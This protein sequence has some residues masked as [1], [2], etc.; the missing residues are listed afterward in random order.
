MPAALRGQ[1]PNYA[2]QRVLSHE[3][4]L[5]RLGVYGI[6]GP[7]RFDLDYDEFASGQMGGKLVRVRLPGHMDF[8]DWALVGLG[9]STTAP[10]LRSDTDR[11][12]NFRK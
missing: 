6:F 9:A 2:V 3:L 8:S 7:P 11:S 10:Y 12:R 4:Q 5:I 1:H